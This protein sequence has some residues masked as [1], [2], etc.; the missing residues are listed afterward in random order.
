MKKLKCCWMVELV[1]IPLLV[2]VIGLLGLYYLH[3][4]NSTPV[5]DGV[6][7]PTSVASSE[8]I[9]TSNYVEGWAHSNIA[10][11]ELK[12]SGDGQSVTISWTDEIG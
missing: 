11:P 3:L 7:A 8:T 10:S 9:D 12:L 1:V 6:V 5:D 4:V 2:I